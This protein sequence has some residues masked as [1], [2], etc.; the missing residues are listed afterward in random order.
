SSDAAMEKLDER[1]DAIRVTQGVLGMK[2][3]RYTVISMVDELQKKTN[4]EVAP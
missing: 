4:M 1:V 3:F 2:L